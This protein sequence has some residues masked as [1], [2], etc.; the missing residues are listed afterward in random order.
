MD[1][2]IINKY[3]IR[4]KP[5]QTNTGKKGKKRHVENKEIKHKKQKRGLINKE[6]QYRSK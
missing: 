6:K 2:V 5:K 4:T 3:A 1:K